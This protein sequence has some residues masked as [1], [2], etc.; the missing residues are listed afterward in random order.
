M[1]EPPSEPRYRVASAIHGVV[2]LMFTGGTFIIAADTPAGGKFGWVIL[3]ILTLAL[4]IRMIWAALTGR[5]PRW[6]EYLI[7]SKD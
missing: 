4:G 2:V 1:L 7:D 5:V 3:G 6:L